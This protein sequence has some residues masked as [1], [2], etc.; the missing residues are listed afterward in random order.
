MLRHDLTDADPI[1]RATSAELVSQ[2]DLTVN[3]SSWLV[4]ALKTELPR[5]EKGEMNDAALAILD[6]LGKQKSKETNQAIKTA[7]EKNSTLRKLF[8][9]GPL[10][11]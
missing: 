4:E 9:E 11:K 1:I 10:L 7:L 6:A 3:H 5:V 2:Q 8:L